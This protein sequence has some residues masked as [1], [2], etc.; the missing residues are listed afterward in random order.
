VF[1]KV[2]LFEGRPWMIELVIFMLFHF[3]VELSNPGSVLFQHINHK[4]KQSGC[5]S[6]ASPHKQGFAAIPSDPYIKFIY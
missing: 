2:N 5:D 3:K 1:L 6:L 4:V